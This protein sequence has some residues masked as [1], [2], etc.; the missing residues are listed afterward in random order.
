[1]AANGQIAQQTQGGTSP[2]ESNSPPKTKIPTLADQN[3]K[4]GDIATYK[5]TSLKNAG[6]L[7]SIATPVGGTGLINVVKDYVWTLSNTD[8]SEIPYVVL[9]EY[10]TDENLI[11]RQIDKF[12]SQVVQTFDR[13]DPRGGG[14]SSDSVLSIYEEMTPKVPTGFKYIFPYFNKNAIELTAQWKDLADAG[15]ALSKLGPKMKAT[16]DAVKTGVGLIAAAGSPSVG[17]QDRPKIFETHVDRAINISFT[18]FNTHQ[19]NDYKK[20]KSLIK[21]LVTQNLFNKRDYITGMPPVFY[22]VFIP[23]QYYSYASHISNLKVENLG[24]MRI[25]DNEIIP[26]AYQIEITLQELFKPS[27]NQFEAIFTGAGQDFVSTTG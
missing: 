13:L 8:N 7:A 16:I 3:Q 22:D 6:S 10:E 4:I 21:L 1:M 5:R 27:K 12:T 26:D 19:A 25:L 17:V 18:L 24:N 9:K 11:T 23:G 15:D 2:G 20:N 14:T